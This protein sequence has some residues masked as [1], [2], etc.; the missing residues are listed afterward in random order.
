MRGRSDVRSPLHC[1]PRQSS[2]TQNEKAQSTC[3][4]ESPFIGKS[5]I[6]TRRTTC[7]YRRNSAVYGRLF[8]YYASSDTRCHVAETIVDLMPDYVSAW[9]IIFAIVSHVQSIFLYLKLK[10]NPLATC[11]LSLINYQS[12]TGN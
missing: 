9:S 10:I 6:Y 3:H 5:W 2:G 4:G 12:A 11:R 7:R 1:L 8:I